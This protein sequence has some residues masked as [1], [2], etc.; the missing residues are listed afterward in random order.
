MMTEDPL[1]LRI[2]WDGPEDC[3][4]LF[5][6]AL[7]EYTLR[8]EDSLSIEIVPTEQVVEGRKLP[9]EIACSPWGISVW[10]LPDA[11]VRERNGVGEEVSGF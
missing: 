3:P 5:E 2:Q 6:P 11:L 7:F 1:T 10:V 8:G 9:I 4:V